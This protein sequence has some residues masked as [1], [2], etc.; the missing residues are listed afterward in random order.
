MLDVVP[1][2]LPFWGVKFSNF[3][4]FNFKKAHEQLGRQHCENFQI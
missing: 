2:E 1:M 4:K 3:L